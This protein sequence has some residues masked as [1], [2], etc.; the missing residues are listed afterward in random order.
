MAI[1]NR[2]DLPSR[3]MEIDLN[4]PDGNAF[5]LLGRANRLGK[6]LGYNQTTRDR[7]LSDMR[8]GNYDN[9]IRVFDEEFGDYV[10]LIR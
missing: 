6:D 10:D 8:S 7:I 2:E 9:L 5:A 3:K 4:G 1:L